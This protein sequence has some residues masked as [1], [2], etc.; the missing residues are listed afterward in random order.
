MK[1]KVL[2]IVMSIVLI[3]TTAL[4]AQNRRTEAAKHPR[5]ENA[6]REL[7]SAVDY[8]EKAPDDF[9]GFKAQAI[10]DS[11][12]AIKSLKHALDY[13]ATVDHVKKVLK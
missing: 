7:E 11:K 4:I 9:G 1:K 10:S 3:S 5:I 8:M 6:I 13:R 12:Q 2:I